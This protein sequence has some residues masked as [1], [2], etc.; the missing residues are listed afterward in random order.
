MNVFRCVATLPPWELVL[1]NSPVVIEPGPLEEE[2]RAL[3]HPLQVL[4]VARLLRLGLEIAA[5]LAAL[6]IQ[7]VREHGEYQHQHRR[8]N[9]ADFLEP[10]G[11]SGGH[12]LSPVA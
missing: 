11:L 3:V 4:F 12:S 10:D 1:Q 6:V 7:H 5:N 8:E 2:R 9:E